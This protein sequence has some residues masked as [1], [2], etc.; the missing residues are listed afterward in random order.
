[1]TD[2]VAAREDAEAAVSRGAVNAASANSKT[3]AAEK[4]KVKAEAE[5][6]E[7][8]KQLELMDAT[9][10]EAAS[11]IA[12]RERAELAQ[13][14][15]E[16]KLALVEKEAEEARAQSEKALREGEER[17]RR[18]A[19]VQS[20]F[21]VTEKELKEKLEKFES[22]LNTLR[23]NA[24][25]AEKMKAEAICIV[26]EAHA[27]SVEV[28]KALASMTSKADELER[29][30]RSVEAEASE[31]LTQIGVLEETLALRSAPPV[32]EPQPEVPKRSASTQ[33][34]REV[35]RE[36]PPL[37]ARDDSLVRDRLLAIMATLNIPTQNVNAQRPERGAFGMSLITGLFAGSDDDEGKASVDSAATD[38]TDLDAL[39]HRV[40]TWARERRG[41]TPTTS[42]PHD[43]PSVDPA[44]MEKEIQTLKDE[45]AALKADEG[46]RSTA[47]LAAVNRRAQEAERAAAEAKEKLAPLERENRELA[48]Q[49][50]MLSEQDESKTR[51]A[52]A[53][54]GWLT[55]A[56]KGC[57]APRRPRSVLL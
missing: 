9:G 13:Q 10:R 18:F 50:A 30:L 8:R 31:S 48:W 42:S 51:P 56:I 29:A 57:T 4:A 23:A 40:E 21:Q 2:A 35:E 55:Q 27:E 12:A 17:K 54:S 15:A 5:L 6:A 37:V 11:S 3:A 26:E 32:P 20:Q 52:L 41:E 36:T 19:H 39:L 33:T 45:L 46:E 24:E 22:E 14:R 1:M 49:I 34:D 47:S 25:E 38:E 44:A 43:A 7:L 16:S 53:Q 28:K